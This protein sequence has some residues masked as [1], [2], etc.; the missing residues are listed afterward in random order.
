MQFLTPVTI[1]IAA[2]LTIPPLVLLYFLRLKRSVADVSST[3]LWKRAI[4]DLRVNAPFQR[5]RNSLLLWLQLLVLILAALA[6]GRPMITRQKPHEQTLILMIDQSASMAVSEEPGRTRLD[7][8]KD[9]AKKVVDAMEADSRAMVVAFCD[10]AI[11]VSSFD[12][13]R[14]ALKRKI[15]TIE[16]TDGVSMLSEAVTL[17]E[18][19]SQNLIIGTSTGTDVAPESA[20]PA[21]S[22]ILFTDGRIGDAP[23]VMPQ[24]LDL[25]KMEVVTIGR[26]TD[27]IGIVAM[28]ARRSYE[29]P[30]MLQVFATVRNFGS[31]SV[32]CDAT[33]YIDGEHLDV[34][35][36][37][38]SPG[39]V[40]SDAAGDPPADD[41]IESNPPPGSVVAIAFDRVEFER[42]GVVEV[43]LNVDD[44]LSADNR[45]WTV[46]HP[47]RRVDLLLVT[48]GNYFL[49]KVL[50][51]LNVN[52]TQMT[53]EQ[54]EQASDDEIIEA[55]RARYDVVVFDGYATG[56]LPVGNYWFWGAVPKIDGFQERG[57]VDDEAIIDWDEAH[58]ILRHASVGHINVFFHWLRIK[59]PDGAIRLI[60]GETEDSTPLA[61]VTKAGSQFLICALPIFVSD[62][63]D[64]TPMLNTDWVMKP[65]FVMFVTDAVQYLSSSAD[66]AGF[67]SIR[68]GDPQSIPLPAGTR[69]VVVRRP[70]GTRDTLPVGGNS[71]TYARTRRVGIY[72]F[73]PAVEGRETLAVN[74][75]SANESRV[76]P[77]GVVVL[78]SETLSVTKGEN[79]VNEPLWPWL[80][81]G[82]L[83]V[84]LFEWV[85]YNKRVYV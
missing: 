79:L 3:L 85:V 68:P 70:D 41:G 51:S 69:T 21:A 55:G 5:L 76:S 31:E 43:R 56:R 45:A 74:L 49:E 60:E 11:M 53:G 54:Y 19:Y 77:R 58:P 23:D 46:I 9:R 81:M 14:A 65:D 84:C 83:V 28:D 36:L 4:E 48:E 29:T 75:F 44:A 25:R 15:D 42:G 20:A 8:A 12:T 16:Q 30:E 72:A 59:L 37:E 34:Q 6:L 62:E 78:G 52:L 35:T 24:R 57:V 18:A 47:P 38:L 26:R 71:V 64:G 40:S 27:N 13:D 17:A 10:R 66:T 22:V 1:A 63:I 80:M 7:I 82:L 73:E 39:L 33:L 2:G 61:Y 50:S 67:G 32:T